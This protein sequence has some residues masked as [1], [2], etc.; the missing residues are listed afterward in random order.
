MVFGGLGHGLDL[1]FVEP[2]A[3]FLILAD[4]AARD[5]MMHVAALA[6]SRVVVG[7]DGIH[8]ININVIMLGQGQ[9]AL[10]DFFGMVAPVGGIEM[11]VARQDL[12]LDVG[13]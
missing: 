3:Q 2:L 13:F 4:D 7:G 10:D 8:D 6:K 1:F 5:E 9:A 12:L 11:L